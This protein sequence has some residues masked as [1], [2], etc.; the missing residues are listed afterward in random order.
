MSRTISVEIEVAG[1]GDAGEDVPEDS[2]CSLLLES[3]SNALTEA[4]ANLTHHDLAQGR[5]LSHGQ[6]VK[7]SRRL[8]LEAWEADE[9]PGEAPIEPLHDEVSGW[10]GSGIDSVRIPWLLLAVDVLD[11]IALLMGP[12]DHLIMRVQ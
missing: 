5:T 7:L 2:G 1:L 9:L 6:V 12:R 11:C 3:A 10:V 4:Q 8:A